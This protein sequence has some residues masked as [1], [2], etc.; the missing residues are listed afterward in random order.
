[1]SRNA[2]ELAEKIR[3]I[4]GDAPVRLGLILGSG[5]GHLSGAVEGVAIPYDELE[6]FPH[7]SVSG[8]VPQLVIGQLEGV[9]VAVFGGRAHY[10]E[11]GARRCH[12]SAAGGSQRARGRGDDRHECGR[13]DGAGYANR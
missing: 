11:T 1:M 7:A 12:A 10:Y 3:E 9:R 5:L 8:H 6:G 4:A 2:K 13:L